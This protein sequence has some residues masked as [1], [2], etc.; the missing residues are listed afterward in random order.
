MPISD[1]LAKQLMWCTSRQQ[2][3]CITR[4]MSELPFEHRLTT[5]PRMTSGS[6]AHPAATAALW[7]LFPT[8]N[9]AEEV[10]RAAGL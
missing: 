5:L 7:G 3:A 2:A 6:F 8:A 1:A 10:R 4:P 9:V